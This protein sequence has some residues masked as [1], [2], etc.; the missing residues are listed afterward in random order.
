MEWNTL[1]RAKTDLTLN[2]IRKYFIYSENEPHLIRWGF[3]ASNSIKIGDIAG[4]CSKKYSQ[5]AI[6]RKL[7]YVH[8]IIYQIIHGINQIPA[9]YEIDHVDGIP[10]NN[11]PANLRISCH[12]ENMMN[13]K[14]SINK[15]SI[16]KG[17]SFRKDTSQW[18]SRIR[19]K[20]KLITIGNFN[21][22]VDAAI[23][24]DNMAIS[25]FGEYA[26]LNFPKDGP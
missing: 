16:Y 23:A 1:S 9:G 15:S 10:T 22:E 13:M 8:R 21:N 26:R 3:S 19:L 14:K 6:K 11:H 12:S 2:E 18:R 17:V 7:Y 5:V 24:Y 4:S 25:L 20:R